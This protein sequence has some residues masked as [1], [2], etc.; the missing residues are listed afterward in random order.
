MKFKKT[1]K[2]VMCQF[3][4]KVVN[5][6]LTVKITIKKISIAVEHEKIVKSIKETF[7][8]GVAVSSEQNVKS[9]EIK[10]T[11]ITKEAFKIMFEI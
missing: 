2:N 5:S 9:T 11:G 1:M 8:D 3:Y 4:A 7:V 6:N 10:S